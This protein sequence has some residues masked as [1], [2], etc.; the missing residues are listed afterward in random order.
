MKSLLDHL[1]QY[2]YYH[3]DRRNVNTHFVG[4]PMIVFAIAVLLS[5]PQF[6]FFDQTLSPAVIVVA[7]TALFYVYLHRIMGLVMTLLFVLCLWGAE[8]LAS[9][10]TFIWLTS[11]IGLFVVGWLFQ[12]VGHYFEGKKPAFLDDITGLVIGPLF[13][14]VEV[15]F[16]LGWK[17]EWQNKITAYCEE[18]N[19]N[20]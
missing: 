11:G 5:R 10:S 14:V 17:S 2:A 1:S 8:K 18:K 12:F 13:V 4:I 19:H 7:V 6:T 3:Q 9:Q 16:L 20:L 15:V